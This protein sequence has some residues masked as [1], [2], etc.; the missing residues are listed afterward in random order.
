MHGTCSKC[1]PTRMFWP[2]SEIGDFGTPG[3]IVR[4]EDCQWWM[5]KELRKNRYGEGSRKVDD[6]LK[7]G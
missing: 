7:P 4:V 1:L 3:M 5:N 2:G 6:D